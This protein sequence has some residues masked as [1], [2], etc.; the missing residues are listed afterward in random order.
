MDRE[1]MVT[2]KKGEIYLVAVDPDLG[3]ENQ[4]TRPATSALARIYPPLL[5]KTDP[6]IL[7]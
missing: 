2:P 5:S 7:T 6:G 3:H 1:E 4:K